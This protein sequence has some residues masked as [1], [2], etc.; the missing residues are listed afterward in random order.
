MKKLIYTK[1][2]DIDQY[3]DYCNK[4]EQ[5]FEKAIAT[6]RDES[7]NDE[8]QLLEILINEYD[9]RKAP[10]AKKEANPVSLLK[11]ILKNSEISQSTL[12]KELNVSRQI[13]SDILNKKRRISREM[14]K[15]LSSHFAMSELAFTRDYMLKTNETISAIAKKPIP[16]IIYK[17]NSST[18]YARE[19][20][21]KRISKRKK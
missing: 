10:L 9:E 17:T 12:A 5:L 4:H 3:V 6:K 8:I 19:N 18:L 13:V 14:A 7:I 2:K 16:K 15:K 20:A 1:I 11:T 21:Q